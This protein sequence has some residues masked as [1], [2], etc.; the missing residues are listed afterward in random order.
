MSDSQPAIDR[1]TIASIRTVVEGLI[2]AALVWAGTNLNALS[3]EMAKVQ[4]RLAAVDRLEKRLDD[5]ENRETAVEQ[6]VATLRNIADTNRERIS[7]LESA[8]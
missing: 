4:T 3:V 6:A 1:G 5:L 7:A 2:L 8:R